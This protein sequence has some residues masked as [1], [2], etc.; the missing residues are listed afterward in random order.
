[1]LDL[2]GLLLREGK[3]KGGREGWEGRQ[4]KGKRR[5]GGREGE[6]GRFDPHFSLP[7]A[8]PAYNNKPLEFSL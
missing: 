6:G 7:S 3:E 2:W 4:R 1:M 8:A 5:G